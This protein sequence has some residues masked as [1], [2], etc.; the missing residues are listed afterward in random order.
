MHKGALRN[1]ERLS[2]LIASW[3]IWFTVYIETETG[4]WAMRWVPVGSKLFVV[5]RVEGQVKLQNNSH[6]VISTVAKIEVILHV[7]VCVCVCVCDYGIMN[8][9]STGKCLMLMQNIL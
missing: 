8:I 4:K 9:S 1:S 6:H 5:G 3:C 7:C 2:Y